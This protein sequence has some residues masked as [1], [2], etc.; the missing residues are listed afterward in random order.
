MTAVA[1]K[2][3]PVGLRRVQIFA[4][5]A[6]GYPAATS[7]AVYEGLSVVGPKTFAL[8]VPDTQ[9]ITHK[10]GDTVLDVD[11]LPPQDAVTGEF[12]F[13]QEDFDLY[14]ALTGTKVA[15]IGEM[16]TIGIG[17][18]K[19]G[20]EPEI[21]MFAVQQ[22]KNG[23]GA[24][25]WRSYVMPKARIHVKD[26]GMVLS[27]SDITAQVLP[28][29][30]T[31]HLWGVAFSIATDG[32]TKAFYRKYIN[33]YFPWIV[34]WKGDNVAT[35]F[36]FHADRPAVATTKIAGVW[37]NGVVDGTAGLAVDGVTPTAKPGAGDMIVCMYEIANPEEA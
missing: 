8:N 18:S 29:K 35:K 12:H 9:V 31:K 14:A 3:L 22:T 37:I 17:T 33:Q 13:A 36:T 16:K 27:D 11:W 32:F 5:D 10:G 21:G 7:T 26:N 28:S 15:T 6:N 25:E 1:G 23:S 19:A 34:A 4:L 2:D 20:F 30:V 24:R